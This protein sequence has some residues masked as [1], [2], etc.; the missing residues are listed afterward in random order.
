MSRDSRRVQAA[1]ES[2]GGGAASAGGLVVAAAQELN[3]AEAV[4]ER[5]RHQGQLAPS[6][7]TM[8]SMDG[9]V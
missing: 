6:M 3:D 1:P 2:R 5:I 8:R 7:L 9:R 4:A